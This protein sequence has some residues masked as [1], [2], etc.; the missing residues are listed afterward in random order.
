MKKVTELTKAVSINY[1]DLLMI[2]QNGENKQ[3]EYE[4]L[5]P[6]K[7]VIQTSETILAN[8]EYE[9]PCSYVAGDNNLEIYVE[10]VLLSK[11][12]HYEEIGEN[13]TTSN[14]VK[15]K[16]DIAEG[17]IITVKLIGEASVKNEQ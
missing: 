8:T 3:I 15:F 16:W 9:L 5:L 7:Y 6:R 14:I 13:E 11:N 1:E 10:G 4:Q 2:V 12:Y 17:S